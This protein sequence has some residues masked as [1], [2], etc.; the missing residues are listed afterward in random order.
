LSAG[1]VVQQQPVKRPVSGR[2]W[3]NK[4]RQHICCYS[5]AFVLNG[6]R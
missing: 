3:R 6:V 1:S 4:A 5:G 2:A